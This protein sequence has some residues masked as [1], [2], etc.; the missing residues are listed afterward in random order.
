[1]G[2]RCHGGSRPSGVNVRGAGSMTGDE[3]SSGDG[4]GIADG[5]CRSIGEG[6]NR[7]D[8]SAL[9]KGG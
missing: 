9:V 1:V 8:S 5:Y 4:C 6:E 2:Q 3:G 7:G